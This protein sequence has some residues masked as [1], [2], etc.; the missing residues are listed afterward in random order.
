M[1]KAPLVIAILVLLALPAI[2]QAP[3]ELYGYVRY[4]D[5]AAARGVAVSVNGVSV[6]TDRNGFYKLGFLK[7]GPVVVSVSPQRKPTRSFRIMV[8]AQPT[9]RDFV[10]DW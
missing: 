4:S 10:V 8:R 2:A 3:S 6:A 7:P 5:N 1:R 9:Q